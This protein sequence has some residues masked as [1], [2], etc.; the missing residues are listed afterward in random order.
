MF[1]IS[2]VQEPAVDFEGIDNAYVHSDADS[3][4][5]GSDTVDTTMENEQTQTPKSVR[6]I[7]IDVHNVITKNIVL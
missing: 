3:S 4:D 6:I 1:I 2:L 7:L 5:S